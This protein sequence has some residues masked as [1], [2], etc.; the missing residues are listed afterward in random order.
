MRFSLLTGLGGVEDYLEIARTAEDTGF[1]SLA[2][3][4]SIFYPEITES[5]YPYMNTDSVRQVLDGVPV[6]DPFVAI[7]TMAAV[8]KK[9]R[10]Y[11]AV[12]KVPVRQPLV[13]AK[14]LS[15]LAVVSGNRVSLGAGLSPWKEDFTFN[16]VDFDG[17]GKLFDECLEIIRAAMSGNYFEHQSD[18]FAIGRCKL[19]PAPS[20]N[21]PILIG[22]HSK[23]ALRRAARIGDGWVSA[24]TD[25][26][27]L[28]GLL[29]ELAE[30]R[31][32]YGTDE[33]TNFEIHAFD[34]YARSIDDYRQ[35]E[36]LGVTDICVTPWNPYDPDINRDKKLAAIES[37]AKVIIENY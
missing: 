25:C 18:N 15:S 24:N 3:P 10:F 9:L 1:N 27:T 6:L 17:R 36:Q 2:I 14:A 11:P 35:L 7:A 16:G 8:T 31:R 5:D 13:L 20:K 33:R 32:E 30:M 23:P 19:S 21:V 22:G 29:S 12:M 4:D 34:V 28:Q 37:F 26:E